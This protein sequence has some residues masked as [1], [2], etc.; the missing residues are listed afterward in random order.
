MLNPPGKPKRTFTPS[1]FNDSTRALAPD[2]LDN[3]NPNL[4]FRREKIV[5]RLERSLMKLKTIRTL[6]QHVL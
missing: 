1:L 2:I 3:V 5:D 4:Y 6:L